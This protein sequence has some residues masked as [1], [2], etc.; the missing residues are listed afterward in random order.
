MAYNLTSAVIGIAIAGIILFLVRGDRLHT[1]YALWWI[2]VALTIA[3]LGVFPRISDAI[4]PHLGISYPPILPLSLA[5]GLLA[6]KLLTMDIER[7][8]NEVKLHRLTQRL[9]MLEGRLDALLPTPRDS[10]PDAPD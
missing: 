10:G 3:L 7:S 8:R 4:A 2:P 1:R 6:I 9:A 5:L